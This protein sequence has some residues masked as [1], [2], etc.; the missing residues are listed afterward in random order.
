MGAHSFTLLIFFNKVGVVYEVVRASNT[1]A[2]TFLLRK[3]AY[4]VF[5]QL[6]AVMLIILSYYHWAL[7]DKDKIL[8][9]RTVRYRTVQLS[10][11]NPFFFISFKQKLLFYSCVVLFDFE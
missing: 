1:F 6:L 2:S 3:L 7:S 5:L 9:R 11:K 4:G 10:P 8:L